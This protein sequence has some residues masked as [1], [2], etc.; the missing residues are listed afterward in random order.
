MDLFT[1]LL[2]LVKL[3]KVNLSDIF[4]VRNVLQILFGLTFQVQQSE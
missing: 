1:R 3:L 2:N 4:G